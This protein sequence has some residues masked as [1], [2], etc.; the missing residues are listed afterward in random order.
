MAKL[1]QRDQKVKNQINIF[2]IIS[3]GMGMIGWGFGIFIMLASFSPLSKSFQFGRSATWFLILLPGVDWLT[4]MITG[5]IGIRQIKRKESQTGI[6][7]ARSGIIMSGLGCALFYGFLLA[8]TY[9]FYM[10]IS[11]GYIGGFILPLGNVPF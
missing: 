10:L 3:L 5:I 8:L 6:G 4:S 2:S 1:D 9:A 7:L 11:K